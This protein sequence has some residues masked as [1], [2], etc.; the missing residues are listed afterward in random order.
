MAN[1]GFIR[2]GYFNFLT[3]ITPDCDCVGWG[4]APVVPDIGILAS[5]DPVAIDAESFDLV[6]R[7]AGL[8][9][10]FLEWN[11]GEGE[12]KFRVCAVPPMATGRSG[13]LR[14]SDSDPPRTGWS[15]RVE[16]F[17]N[18]LNDSAPNLHFSL[19]IRGIL[20]LHSDRNRY[21]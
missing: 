6:N 21:N 13:T 4:D 7:Q 15:R 1:I 17:Y 16:Q 19:K 8:K 11:F 5:R 3:Q 18:P 9:N 14:R 12:D 20:S 10:S 2:V